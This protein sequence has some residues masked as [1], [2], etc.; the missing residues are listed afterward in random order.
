MR[1][2]RWAII[3]RALRG[4]EGKGCPRVIPTPRSPSFRDVDEALAFLHGRT[5][6]VALVDPTVLYGTDGPNLSDCDHAVVVLEVEI[7]SKVVWFVIMTQI[8]GLT[9]LSTDT[10]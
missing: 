4:S 10:E 6:Y 2:W 3:T 7:Q 9:W 1:N 5:P 8:R